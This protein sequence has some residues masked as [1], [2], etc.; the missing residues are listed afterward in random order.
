MAARGVVRA[1]SGVAV[2]IGV[3]GTTGA[4]LR[5]IAVA[6]AHGRAVAPTIGVVGTTDRVVRRVVVVRPAVG[7]PGI[8][9]RA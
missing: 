9:V 8:A 3:V 2:A 5:M 6:T 1:I 7:L 4:R